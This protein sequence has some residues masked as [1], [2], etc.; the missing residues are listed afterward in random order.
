M[1]CGEDVDLVNGVFLRFEPECHGWLLDWKG[2]LDE[3]VAEG[4]DPE[5][6]FL[7]D[8]EDFPAVPRGG[9]EGLVAVLLE[10]GFGKFDF[11]VGEEPLGLV[12]LYF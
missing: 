11:G 12:S 10:T 3:R 7:H 8:A 6:P 2:G 9:T 5:L 4:E 1:S